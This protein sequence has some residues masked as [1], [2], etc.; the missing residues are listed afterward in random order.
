MSYDEKEEIAM[1]LSQLESVNSKELMDFATQ[2]TGGRHLTVSKSELD[3]LASKNN[4]EM[5]NYQ[6]KWAVTVLRGKKNSLSFKLICNLSLKASVD[7]LIRDT[8]QADK[9]VDTR[10]KLFISVMYQ[11]VTITNLESGFLK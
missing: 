11:P 9:A 7:K 10:A 4:A 5:T 2:E 1:V 6:T 8:L 3:R